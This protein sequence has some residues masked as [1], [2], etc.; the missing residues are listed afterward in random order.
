METWEFGGVIERRQ[1][2][3][4]TRQNG[5]YELTEGRQNP[6][7]YRASYNEQKLK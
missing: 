5:G 3:A 1:L 6:C 2:K 7:E 4:K